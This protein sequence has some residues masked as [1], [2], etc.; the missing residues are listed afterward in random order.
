VCQRLERLRGRIGQ[1]E[2]SHDRAPRDELRRADVDRDAR[3]V[4]SPNDDPLLRRLHYS[5]QLRGEFLTGERQILGRDDVSDRPATKIA[6]V[7]DGGSVHP[8]DGSRAVEYVC[9]DSQLGDRR[10]EVGRDP[11]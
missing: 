2:H 8:P 9:R 4:C 7:G 6:E 3:T 5:E 11:T 10:R 1:A